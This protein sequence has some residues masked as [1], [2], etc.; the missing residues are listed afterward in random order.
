MPFMKNLLQKKR[1]IYEKNRGVL[2]V[3]FLENK[4]D[5]K[6]NELWSRSLSA[7]KNGKQAFESYKQTSYLATHLNIAS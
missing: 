3:S 5:G 2:R 6:L 7:L 1:E 4:L